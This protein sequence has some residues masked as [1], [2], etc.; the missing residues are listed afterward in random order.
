MRNTHRI[1][2]GKLDGNG[3]VVGARRGCEDNIKLKLRINIVQGRS[4]IY[5]VEDTYQ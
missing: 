2:A 1:L 3:S 4:V 5:V